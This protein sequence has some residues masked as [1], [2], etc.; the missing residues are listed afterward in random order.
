MKQTGRR[1]C[2]AGVVLPVVQKK[3]S[4]EGSYW[5]L[6]VEGVEGDNGSVS[7]SCITNSSNDCVTSNEDSCCGS[8]SYCSS[9]SYGKM[10]SM[11]SDEVVGAVEDLKSLGFNSIFRLSYIMGE[12]VKTIHGGKESGVAFGLPG[13]PNLA[14]TENVLKVY[15]ESIFDLENGGEKV[16]VRRVIG[17]LSTELSDT[18]KVALTAPLGEM[19]M[20][21]Y[22]H[23]LRNLN[24]SDFTSFDVLVGVHLGEVSRE[25]LDSQK[26]SSEDMNCVSGCSEGGCLG[27]LGKSYWVLRQVGIDVKK[28][29]EGFS[30]STTRIPSSNTLEDEYNLPYDEDT[31]ARKCCDLRE[32]SLSGRAGRGGH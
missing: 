32:E 1:A 3:G 9:L 21:G 17:G 15:L 6:S 7:C 26:V 19:Q 24:S 14:L 30:N 31:M 23:T 12:V 27:M 11:G 2:C 13:L 29:S 22:S 10:T 18:I 5:L 8:G 25:Y 16:A 4:P 28:Y 20:K